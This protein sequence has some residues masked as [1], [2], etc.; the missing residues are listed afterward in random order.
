MTDTDGGGAARRIL[1]IAIIGGT[2]LRLVAGGLL[3]LG[4]DEQYALA[5][6]REF[7]WSFLDHP[8]LGFWMGTLA[9]KLGGSAA[10]LAMR[11]PFIVLSI[12]TTLL[13]YRFTSRLFGRDAGAWSAAIFNLC[14][15]FSI[16]AGSWIMP[17]GPLLAAAIGSA[18]CLLPLVLEGDE[19]RVSARTAWIA[20]LGA[21]VLLGLAMLA[22]YLAVFYA[23]G[24]VVFVASVPGVR[25][26]LWHPAPYVACLLG[27]AVFAPVLWWNA[28]HDWA[29]FAFQGGRAT[30]QGGLKPI[31]VVQMIFG[32]ALYL[33][34]WL[35]WPM[36]AEGV[37]AAKPGRGDRGAW[38]C[39]CIAVPTI[40]ALSIIPLWGKR[41]LPHWPA[42]G[43]LFLLPMLGR[44]TA[45]SLAMGG[46]PAR[47]VRG[48]LRFSTVALAVVAIA[49]IV[50]A[51]TGLGTPLI[52]EAGRAKDPTLDTLS[53][54]PLADV[55]QEAGIEPGAT[56]VVLAAPHWIQGGRLGAALGDRWPVIV[57][58]QAAHHFPF[59]HGDR[60]F[61]GDDVVFA[62]IDAD[63][64]A[65]V[66]RF[67][68]RFDLTEP[69]GAVEL[70]RGGEVVMRLS[71]VKG[72]TLRRPLPPASS[73]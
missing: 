32:A 45:A 16:V 29:S 38:F 67:G 23:F 3:G 8:P 68:D 58:D 24:V 69:L 11:W 71:A 72:V 26:W 13:L 19:H 66:S 41:G 4:I 36:L 65:A 12:A 57:A 1:L 10:P 53:W 15:L 49:L 28:T 20:W 6:G 62:G 63:V 61:V 27:L 44:A 35:W 37:K 17:D 34:P 60:D 30:N 7:Q 22:K 25:R 5:V 2:L 31:Y 59:L 51:R 9:W 64:D 33:T 46:S 39:L 47:V 70:V 43:F 54:E 50:H 40:L 21:G 52:P 48:W 14:P 55:L 42:I 73:E 18:N 56:D